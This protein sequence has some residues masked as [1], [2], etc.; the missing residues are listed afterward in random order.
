MMADPDLD[1]LVDSID[2]TVMLDS[3]DEEDENAQP[4][5]LLTQTDIT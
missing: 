3:G 2:D 4:N 1:L 5:T